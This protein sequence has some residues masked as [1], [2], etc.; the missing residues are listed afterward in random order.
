MDIQTDE[1]ELAIVI[2]NSDYGS[3]ALRIAKRNGVRG[4]TVFFGMGTLKS[5]ILQ[6]L[7]LADSR[8]EIVLFAADRHTMH[9]A[10][11][12]IDREFVFRKPN[13]GIAFTMPLSV[14]MKPGTG[15]YVYKKNGGEFM[16]SAIIV[17]V[18]RGESERVMEAATKAGA[19]GGT[20][21]K[22][23]GAG[24]LEAGKLFNMDIEPEKEI[25]LILSDATLTE[26]ISVAI[27][28]RLGVGEHGK[29][30]IFCLDVREVFGLA[31]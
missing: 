18:P 29:G 25:V 28:N 26:K 4:G 9:K 21:I 22:A 23:R 10:I 17:I 11:E 2:V 24:D 15:E 12:Q 31:E 3:R 30:A 7:E 1:M 19:R 14:C 5:R 6:F 8:K 27:G 13:H 20:L 16:Y